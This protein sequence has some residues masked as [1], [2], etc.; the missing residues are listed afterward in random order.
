MGP[1]DRMGRTVRTFRMA[2]CGSVYVGR[3]HMVQVLWFRYSGLGFKYGGV[4]IG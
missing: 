3:L 2:T 4:G 1:M